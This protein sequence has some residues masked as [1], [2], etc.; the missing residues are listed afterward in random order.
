MA[1]VIF[2]NWQHQHHFDKFSINQL[3]LIYLAKNWLLIVLTGLGRNGSVL[4]WYC[5][6]SAISCIFSRK[7]LRYFRRTSYIYIDYR[8]MDFLHQNCIKGKAWNVRYNEKSVYIAGT[9]TPIIITETS[10]VWSFTPMRRDTVS[11]SSWPVQ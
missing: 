4:I 5:I 10:I 8:S 11:L 6:F 7:F 1:R 3:S 2:L 9:T